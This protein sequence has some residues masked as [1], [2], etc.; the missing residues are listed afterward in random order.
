MVAALLLASCA[1]AVVEEEEEDAMPSAKEQVVLREE[2]IPLEKEVGMLKGTGTKLDGT[3]V[4]KIIEKPRY[5]GVH[6]WVTDSQPTIFDDVIQNRFAAWAI[7][8]V[9]ETLLDQDWQRGPAGTGEWSGVLNVS[10]GPHEIYT[11]RLAESWE[12]PEPDTLVFHIRR[13]VLWVF[14]LASVMLAG[15]WVVGKRPPKTSS[16]V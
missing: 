16:L 3:V 12:M 8:P 5:G 2:V 6:V 15:W 4:E 10:S 7:N 1:L 9:S 13:G 14:D 11:G